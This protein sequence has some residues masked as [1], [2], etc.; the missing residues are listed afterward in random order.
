MCFAFNPSMAAKKK[1]VVERPDLAAIFSESKKESLMTKF[2]KDADKDAVEEAWRKTIQEHAEL[3]ADY[4]RSRLYKNP[5]LQAYV[6]NLGQSMVPREANAESLVTFKIINDPVP[7]VYALATGTVFI[8]TGMISLMENESQLAFVLAHE[9]AHVLANHHL[10]EIVDNQER[11][12]KT[13]RTGKIL[14]V[15]GAVAGAAAASNSDSAGGLEGAMM[16]A[17]L[18]GSGGTGIYGFFSQRGQVKYSR[19]IETDA[20][21]IGLEIALRRSYDIRDAEKLVAEMSRVSDSSSPEVGLSFASDSKMLKVRLE[22]LGAHLAGEFKLAIDEQLAGDGFH[23]GS[24]KFNQLM[25]ELKRDNGLMALY[26]DLFI[27]AKTNLESAAEIRTDDPVTMYGLGLLYR[28]VGRTAE[29][30]YRTANYFKSAIQFDRGR[31][32]FPQAHLEYAVE[33]INMEDP[34]IHNEIQYH[35]K[36]YVTLYQRKNGG[37]LPGEMRFIYDYLEL[38]GDANWVALP[39]IN[40]TAQSPNEFTRDLKL[41]S[42]SH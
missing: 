16:G 20:D 40:T 30:R 5:N 39:V 2:K 32:R 42:V 17:A 3:A 26:S 33:L 23:L 18:F 36:S 27:I 8:T 13:K 19:K 15:V 21:S 11:M 29:E 14:S 1:K 6:N 25:S 9:A 41:S 24:P 31:S 34:T 28:A 4:N 38:A 35:L 12:A 22:S 7:E 10:A 37:A